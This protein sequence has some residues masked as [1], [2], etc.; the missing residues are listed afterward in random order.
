LAVFVPGPRGGSPEPERL[1]GALAAGPGGTVVVVAESSV[2][3][4]VASYGDPPSYWPVVSTSVV[5][6]VVGA[7]EAAVGEAVVAVVGGAV[8][9]VGRV[10]G[11]V[12][13]VGV[14]RV[15]A[16]VDVGPVV[17]V[18]VSVVAVESPEGLL[19]AESVPV[20]SLFDLRPFEDF[21][22]DDLL[23]EDLVS[24]DLASDDVVVALA[25]S[26]G[27]WAAGPVTATATPPPS[28]R[29]ATTRSA[30]APARAWL[31]RLRRSI[32]IPGVRGGVQGTAGRP[33]PQMLR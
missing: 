6:V 28:D 18:V 7:V 1:A 20:V 9:A 10:V 22:S 33:V 16:V 14:R 15:V 27:G 5:S 25:A 31:V 26:A 17:A 29:P 12:R 4:S 32:A 13:V 23:S 21:L 2:G 3:A 8:V 30:P 24:E 19:S 11:V